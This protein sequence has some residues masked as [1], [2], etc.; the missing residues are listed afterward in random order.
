[1]LSNTGEYALRAMIHLAEHEGEGPVRVEDVASALCVPRNYLSKIL[2]TL[3]KRGIL[4]SLRG[5]RG[6]FR[7][8]VPSAL[9][10]LYDV[11]EAFDDIEARRTCL[12]GGRACG[13]AAPCAVHERWKDVATEVAL[14]FRETKLADVV[15]DGSKVGVILG[16]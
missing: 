15:E 1:M 11:V 16:H 5:P 9:V 10:S 2:H 6:G 4:A 12:L 14:F 7:L 13:D 8:A 3:V